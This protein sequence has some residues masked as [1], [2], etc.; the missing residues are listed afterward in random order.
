M[1][2][3]SRKN[4]GQK[5]LVDMNALVDEYLRLSYH[6]QRAQDKSF[7]VTLKTDYDQALG[8]VNVVPQDISRVLLNLFNNAFY[9]ISKKKEQLDNNFVPE[10]WVGTKRLD[11]IIELRVKDNGLGIPHKNIHKIFQPFFTTKP[12]GEG[13]GLGLSLSYDILT[14]EHGGDIKVETVEGAFA[15]FIVQLPL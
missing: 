6:G 9:S 3:H 7:N 11:N 10:V 15:E 8:K 5:E 12:T 13:T 2:Q 14:K 1:L 4:T